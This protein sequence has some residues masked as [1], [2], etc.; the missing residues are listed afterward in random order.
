L[1][2]VIDVN[3][4]MVM[5]ACSESEHLLIPL[6][7]PQNF[8]TCVLFSPLRTF[9]AANRMNLLP[10]EENCM[11]FDRI[12][13]VVAESIASDLCGEDRAL[14]AKLF[15]S[16]A[17]IATIWSRFFLAQRLM[18]RFGLHPESIPS[19]AGISDHSLW[20]QFDAMTMFLTSA[21]FSFSQLYITH[22][23]RIPL[24]SRSSRAMMAA[25]LSSLD[26]P[27]PVL[28]Q[29]SRFMY[30]SPENC[31]AMAECLDVSHLPPFS[32]ARDRSTEFFRAWSIVLSGLFLGRPNAAARYPTSAEEVIHFEDVLRDSQSESFLLSSIVAITDAKDPVT[33]DCWGESLPVCFSFLF[34]QMT[35][36]LLREWIALFLHST[37]IAHGIDPT[38]DAEMNLA[39]YA[40]L[41]LTD[42]SRYT[43]AAGIAILS[44][45][46]TDG[47]P[48][49]NA[50]LMN[51]AILATID[52]SALVRRSLVHCISVYVRFS[53][54]FSDDDFPVDYFLRNP[55]DKRSSC[56]PTSQ[57]IRL[58]S[59][60]PDAEVRRVAAAIGRGDFDF[61]DD[62]D[63]K[64]IHRLAHLS[65]FS[66]E[67]APAVPVRYPSLLIE[68][69]EL[70]CLETVAFGLR[71][72]TTVALIDGALACG[73][74]A[75]AVVWGGSRWA[76]GGCV[77]ALCDVGRG[78][79]VA[80]TPGG[81]F[82]LVRGGTRPVECFS[83]GIRERRAV[84]A[85]CAVPDT[86]IVCIVQ[87]NAEV[88]V[89]DWVT[90]LVIGFV[91]VPAPAVAIAAVGECVMCLQESGAVARID[92]RRCLVVGEFCCGTGARA[93]GEHRGRTYSV[94]GDGKVWMWDGSGGSMWAGGNGAYEAVV[95]R[96]EDIAL[97][98]NEEGEAVVLRSGVGA[99]AM[100]TGVV[101]AFCWDTTMTLCALGHP[102]GEVSVWWVPV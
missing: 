58:L 70:Y 99:V 56:P 71:E 30:G 35:T 19:I 11:L 51:V 27:S 89:W 60:D 90:L 39:S 46:M 87:G 62:W 59:D 14:F 37:L 100:Q 17:F 63:G 91:S 6:D 73:D 86:T 22:F 3:S 102:N 40:A 28:F 53:G 50:D 36:P 1:K 67:A 15:C 9:T 18:P 38:R 83:P 43:R 12:L 45:L 57:V 74:A 42:G 72:I 76:L 68:A 7:L 85:V 98:R 94:H 88:I 5:F 24:P 78:R 82:L 23:S 20:T 97:A 31:R 79:L 13:R 29:L 48:R 75:G 8:L 49:F 25:L 2:K 4:S 44:A 26:D 33:Y 81:L 41:L 69:N 65:L 16:G 61:E 54:S 32:A 34:D 84:R 101:T 93:I 92:P 55:L 10:T 21:L 77:S 52:G 66:S 80:V 64:D 95:H 47:F 96:K